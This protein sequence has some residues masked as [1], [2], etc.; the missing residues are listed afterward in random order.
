MNY[1]QVWQ[2]LEWGEAEGSAERLFPAAR[3][4]QKWAEIRSA[5]YYSE[6]IHAIRQENEG[7]LSKPIPVLPFSLYKR[8]DTTGSR[9]EY[10]RVYF[11]R[12]KRLS[13]L[14]FACLLEEDQR[15]SYAEA[16]EDTIW[17]ICDEYT[18]CLPAHLGGTSMQLVEEGAAVSSSRQAA[19][20]EH[21]RY[22]I[23]LF[24]AETAFALAE[25]LSLV[26][27]LVTPVVAQRAEQE[28]RQRVLEPFTSLGSSYSWETLGNNWASVCA[29]SIGAA[30]LY[31]LPH[32]KE[33]APLLYRVLG[34]MS[35]YLDG[36]GDDG[37]CTEGVGYWN[38]GFGFYLFF[39]EL[40]KERTAGAINLMGNEKVRQIAHFHQKCYLSGSHTV[41]FSDTERKAS[42]STGLIHRLKEYYPEV[43]VPPASQRYKIVE[44]PI[45]RWAPFIRD[46]VWSHAEW[47]GEEW[48]EGSD[49]LPDAQWLIHRGRIGSRPFAFAA[50]GGHNDEPHNH[51]DLG[52]FVLHI[53][54]ESL[55]SD[56]GSGEYTK[57]YFGR[58][59]Y[60][61]L[62]NGSQGH[63]VPIIDGGFQQPGDERRAK[64]LV[65]DREPNRERLV[66][67][68]TK[69]YDCSNLQSLIREFTITTEETQVEADKQAERKST[70][71][72]NADAVQIHE[73]TMVSVELTDRLENGLKPS[74]FTS[75]MITLYQPVMEDDQSIRVE[76][77]HS[78]V[79]MIYDGERIRASVQC[80]PF[81]NKG[82]E[83]EVV[84]A[85][86]F[87][88]LDPRAVD[89][90]KVRLEG[91]LLRKE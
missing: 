71:C 29:G 83:P 47:T 66:L 85:I 46:F 5:P 78:G 9:I 82:S 10:E 61:Y 15:F 13:L 44:D 14:A 17:A 60:S 25:I 59:R 72:D 91:Y 77:A 19:Q 51:N 73:R 33:L 16:L 54:G 22:A 68:L 65:Y 32:A 53:D 80:Y 49:Y 18:W 1:R 79:R 57:G 6:M 3:D 45:G 88:L 55:V 75:R 38:Y 30:A 87:T 58:E 70:V 74:A 42:Y 37:A 69:A 43:H 64:V 52:S 36:F 76:G 90:M 56:L 4:Q 31:V 40:L 39:A 50:K 24:A 27:E 23:D 11:E 34:T 86:D 48:P 62:C 81:I 7:L 21:P 63:S 12:R 2:A 35:S 89:E 20:R 41:P 26:K 8:F 84:Y 28:I 67:D